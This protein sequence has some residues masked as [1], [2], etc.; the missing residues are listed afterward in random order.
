MATTIAIFTT[1]YCFLGIRSTGPT[2]TYAKF[3]ARSIKIESAVSF[4]ELVSVSQK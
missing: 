4:S 1:V 3:V 2:R